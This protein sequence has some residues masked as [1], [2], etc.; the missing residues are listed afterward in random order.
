VAAD[1]IEVTDRVF[2]ITARETKA[3]LKLAALYR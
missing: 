2:R 3:I 1:L